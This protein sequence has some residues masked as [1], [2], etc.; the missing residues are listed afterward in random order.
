MGFLAPTIKPKRFQVRERH[1][2]YAIIA[3]HDLLGI[4]CHCSFGVLCDC[5]VLCLTG[6]TMSP[7]IY[8]R[9]Q[10]KAGQWGYGVFR[11]HQ[12]TND[13]PI[14]SRSH[15]YVVFFLIM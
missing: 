12:N 4:Q 8:I 11:I 5:L 14:D 3:V 15:R 13:M 9:V 7:S 6:G 10:I 1:V 2:E